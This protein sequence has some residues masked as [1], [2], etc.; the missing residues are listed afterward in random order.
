MREI[1]FLQHNADKWKSFGTLIRARKKSRPDQVA[2]LS[3]ELTDDLS[4][5]H[6]FYPKSKITAYLNGLTAKFHQAVFRNKKEERRRPVTFWPEEQTRLFRAYWWKALV[7]LAVFAAAVLTGMV[8]SANHDGFVRFILG[9]G[10]VN[11]TLNN[12]ERSQG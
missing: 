5:A 2:E 7:S 3:I 8:P 10:Y 12:I 4:S 1:Q 11:M 9:D 6:A